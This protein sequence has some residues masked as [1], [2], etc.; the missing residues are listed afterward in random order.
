VSDKVDSESVRLI[1]FSARRGPFRLSRLDIQLNAERIALIGVNGSGKT[2][3]LRSMLGVLRHSG[4]L[5]VG[6]VSSAHLPPERTGFVPQDVD[7]PLLLT[8]EECVGMAADL[9]EVPAATRDRSV[10]DALAAVDLLDVRASRAARL[11]GGQ[12]RRLACAQALVHDPQ[13]VLMDEPTAGLDP[14]QRDRLRRIL[15]DLPRDRLVLVTSHILEDVAMWAERFLIL[16]E[17]EI[18]H[19]LQHDELGDPDQ[20]LSALNDLLASVPSR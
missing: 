3:L 5:L 12:K 16:S 2:T 10:T 9:K 8:V 14:I 7:F 18:I 4:T 17:G 1:A 15:Q 6:D 11:S 20:R 13:I 19:D